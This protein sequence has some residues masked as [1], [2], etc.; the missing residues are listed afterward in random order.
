MD[1]L[2]PIFSVFIVVEF[3]AFVLSVSGNAI[4]CYV[5]IFKKKH[6][7]PSMKYILSSSFADFLAGMFAIPIGFLKVY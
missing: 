7:K 2:G 6:L 4:V 1:S 3:V 5:L